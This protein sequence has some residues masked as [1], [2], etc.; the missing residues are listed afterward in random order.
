MTKY[1][2]TRKT[3]DRINTRLLATHK[4]VIDTRTNELFFEANNPEDI[5]NIYEEF[6]NLDPHSKEY[7]R[8][9]KIQILKD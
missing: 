6:W 8:V 1:E 4:E 7:V 3:Y 2:V 5:R 9:D